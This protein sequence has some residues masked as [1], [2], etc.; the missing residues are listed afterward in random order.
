MLALRLGLEAIEISARLE[1]GAPKTAKTS[2]QVLR[3]K[4]REWPGNSRLSVNKR[5]PMPSM[6]FVERTRPRRFSG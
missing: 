3:A 1:Q 2:L 4:V 5:E 6:R